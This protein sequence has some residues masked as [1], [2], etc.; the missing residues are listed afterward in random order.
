[1]CAGFVNF[2][3]ADSFWGFTFSLL[4]MSSR[5]QNQ[6]KLIKEVSL[7]PK[8]VQKGKCALSAFHGYMDICLWHMNAGASRYLACSV[9]ADGIGELNAQP[10]IPQSW[11]LRGGNDLT[12]V[13]G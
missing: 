2:C 8:S 10:S 4:M 12:N 7:L 11:Q 5:R 6:S 9:L 3:E 1:M 13:L